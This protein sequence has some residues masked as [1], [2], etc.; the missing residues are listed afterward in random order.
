ML[1]K[2]LL[3][4]GNSFLIATGAMAGGKAWTV[5]AGIATTSAGE[6]LDGFSFQAGTFAGGF[7]PTASNF[8]DWQSNW[9]IPSNSLTTWNVIAVPGVSN[10]GAS[11]RSSTVF[12]DDPL[13]GGEQGYI[14]GFNSKDIA[15]TSEW[16]LITN[17]SWTFP[18]PSIRGGD[19]VFD[20]DPK[21]STTDIGT[22]A[23]LGSLNHAGNDDAF[24]RVLT[25][26]AIPEP[27]TYAL[28]FG[29]GILGFLG[30]RRVR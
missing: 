1:K 4:S 14:W 11:G 16:I 2:I 5:E 24:S 28:I 8:S 22:Y 23:I 26:Q 30:Y 10:T 13:S 15:G 6:S 21:W 3:I 18:A 25:T 9:L 19:P 20:V 7:M 29:L 12:N 17:D 27:S